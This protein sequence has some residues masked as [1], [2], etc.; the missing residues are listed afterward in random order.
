MRDLNLN[1]ERLCHHVDLKFWSKQ[2]LCEVSVSKFSF[3]FVDFSF[4]V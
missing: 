1:Y 4:F 2:V 3:F